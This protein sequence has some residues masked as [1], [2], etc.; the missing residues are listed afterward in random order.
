MHVSLPFVV[1]T[2]FCVGI[3][4]H[5]VTATWPFLGGVFPCNRMYKFG[6]QCN[7]V[8]LYTSVLHV[9]YL[10]A[11]HKFNSKREYTFCV[12]DFA[13]FVG[14]EETNQLCVGL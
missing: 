13:F 6:Y 14:E 9:C 7:H 5:A 12:N 1:F 10:L 3:K 2:F 11:L 4:E 8:D